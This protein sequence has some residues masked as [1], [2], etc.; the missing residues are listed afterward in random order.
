MHHRTHLGQQQPV[1]RSAR[2]LVAIETTPALATACRQD[3]TV[4]WLLRYSRAGPLGAH[5]NVAFHDELRYPERVL[6][7]MREAGIVNI[8]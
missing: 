1:S 6:L 7:P 2:K 3:L 8:S 4:R 5:L